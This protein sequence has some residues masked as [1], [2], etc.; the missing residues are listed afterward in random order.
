MTQPL[1]PLGGYNT[2]VNYQGETLHIQTE[3]GGPAHPHISTHVFADG[4]RIIASKRT[5]YS[6]WLSDSSY[7]DQVKAT[8]RV[9]HKD[10]LIALRNGHYDELLHPPK[11]G[12]TIKGVAG[13]GA[14]P[15]PVPAH[16]TQRAPAPHDAENPTRVTR[17]NLD[18]IRRRSFE[19]VVWQFAKGDL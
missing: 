10:M 14:T 11:P 5:D 17:K 4:G 6:S 19:E 2:N 1:Q 18:P 9:Q 15:P 16:L 13:K 7:R 12:S 3:D 8:M